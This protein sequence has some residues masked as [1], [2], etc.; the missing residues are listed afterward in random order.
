MMAHTATEKAD[1]LTAEQAAELLQVHPETVREWLRRGKIPGG[2]AGPRGNWRI[3]RR[4]LEAAIQV[5]GNEIAQARGI[6]AAAAL[7]PDPEPARSAME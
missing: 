3:Q 6:E 5:N 2:R 7:L 1:W 4:G